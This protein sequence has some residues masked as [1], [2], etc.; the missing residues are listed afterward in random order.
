MIVVDI[1]IKL[2]DYILKDLDFWMIELFILY[3]VFMKR[4]FK[5]KIYNHQKF[6]IFYNLTF[7][8]ILKVITILL[9]F[10][11]DCNEG[12]GYKYY[13][14]NGCTYY[15]D[16]DKILKV[17]YVKY[18]WLVPLGIIIYIGIITL[19]SWIYTEIKWFMDIKNVS[20]NKILMIY[21]F[22]GATLCSLLC[23]LSSSIEC[24]SEIYYYICK[25]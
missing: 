24:N 4:I 22:F 7:P 25:V 16:N 17:L 1:L 9:S 8:S 20:Q 21:G 19:R 18:K 5:I 12:E 2:F 13:N 23:W 10:F 3:Y 15:N 14:S 11:D 6:A